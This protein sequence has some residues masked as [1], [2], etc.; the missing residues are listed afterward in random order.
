MKVH[1]KSGEIIEADKALI[2]VGVQG[3]I[4]NLGLANCNITVEEGWIKS[5]EYMGTSLTT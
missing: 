4:E 2:A 3:N 1:L 5:N